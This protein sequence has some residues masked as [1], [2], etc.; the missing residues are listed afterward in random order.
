MRVFDFDG[1]IYR[2]DST[3]DFYLFCLG[4]QPSLAWQ[5]GR[6][7][8]YMA[9]A[10]WRGNGRT[11]VK[12][13]FYSFIPCVTEIESCVR[14]FWEKNSNKVN[15]VVLKRVRKGDLVISASP[16][17]LLRPFCDARGFQLIASAV[18]P[19]TGECMGANCRGEEKVRRFLATYSRE[20]IEE[21]Y[22][23]ST[24]DE[25]LARCAQQ[26]FLVRKK[27]IV[28]FFEGS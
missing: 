4:R 9:K 14:D 28:P 5:I 12:E 27:S 17:F 19:M 20:A 15:N 11:V 3:L 8:R 1:T 24:S 26:S 2:G 10:L 6:Q 18:D 13:G 21:F 22:S 25:P 7:L 23:D 16:E